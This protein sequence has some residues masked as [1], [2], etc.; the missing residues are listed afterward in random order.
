MIRK[1]ILILVVFPVL[2]FSQEKV[3][4]L[5]ECIKYA[6]LHNQKR[7]QQEAQNA[8]YK[9]NQREAIGGFLPS[10]NIASGA[11]MSFGR[12]VNPETNTYILTNT[13]ENPYEIRSSM[14]LFDGLA[15]I[16]RAKMAKLNRIKGREELRNVQDKTTFEVMEVFFNALYYKGTVELA[17]QQLDESLNNLKKFERLEALGLKAAP[18]VAE[19]QAKAAEDR[20]VLTRQANLYNMEIIKLKEKMNFPPENELNVENYDNILPVNKETESVMTIYQQALGFLPAAQAA[21]QSLKISE[22]EYKIARGRLLPSLSVDARLYTG[23]SRLMDGNSYVSFEDQLKNRRG[24]YVG[25]SLSIPIFNGFAYSSEVKRSQQRQV[26]TQSRYNETLRQIYSEIEQA[27]ADV[28]GLSD[29]YDHAKK[30]SAAMLVAHQTNLR[31][32]EEGLMGAIELSTSANRLLNARVEE[33]HTKL[34]Y[35]LKYRLLQYYKGEL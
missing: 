11:S 7:I 15:Q 16:Y 21:D 27:I 4:T 1:I 18:D 32:Y 6:M 10:L 17:Q 28:N 29:E 31:K 14:T 20:F 2:A 9:I 3:W 24:S 13:F 25:F 5:D 23:F 34:K 22:M 30:R 26:I 8:I 35:Y 12:G 19:I 33:L